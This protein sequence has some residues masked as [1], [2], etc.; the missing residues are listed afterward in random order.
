MLK[1]VWFVEYVRTSAKI[2]PPFS[3]DFESFEYVYSELKRKQM[4]AERRKMYV[5][6]F[7]SAVLRIVDFGVM[8]FI[9]MVRFHVCNV[10]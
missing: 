7:G 2:I 5:P 8:F 10:K 9:L 1:C 6:L 4:S 3:D